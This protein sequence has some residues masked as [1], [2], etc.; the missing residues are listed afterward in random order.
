MPNRK[1]EKGYRLELEARK[2][3]EAAGYYVIRSAGSHSAVDLVAVSAYVVRFIQVGTKGS[4]GKADI[5]KLK[6]IPCPTTV[7]KAMWLKVE[8]KAG[9][10]VVVV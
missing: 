4:K 9:F 5:D 10:E 2:M 8:G 1:Y 3:L 6:A 7:H